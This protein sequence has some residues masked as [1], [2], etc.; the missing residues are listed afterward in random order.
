[1][2]MAKPWSIKRP[3]PFCG[4]VGYIQHQIPIYGYGLRVTHKAC[5]ICDGLGIIS[6]WETLKYGKNGKH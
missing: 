6:N 3:C 4:G 5:D 2:A 1:M